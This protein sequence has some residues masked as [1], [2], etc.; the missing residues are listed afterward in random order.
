MLDPGQPDLREP[1]IQEE[2]EEIEEEAHGDEEDA[3]EEE[4]EVTVQYAVKGTPF[5]FSRA[6]SL[7][8]LEEV[9]V[10]EGKG[11]K[12]QA[13]PE[14]GEEKGMA[15]TEG[16]KREAEGLRLL[17]ICPRRSSSVEPQRCEVLPTKLLLCSREHH[18]WPPWTASTTRT[19]CTTAT[20]ATKALEQ[21]LV[22]SHPPTCPTLQA[23]QCQHLLDREDL[24]L[25]Q[26]RAK[27]QVCPHWLPPTRSPCTRTW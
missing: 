10:G 23:K 14:T 27:P 13:I 25:L 5:A 19:P 1:A 15:E 3:G 21:P 4:K 26:G 7:S 24:A 16:E 17:H 8:D 2:E 9:E 12:L 18:R 6:E 11:A 22:V 20:R